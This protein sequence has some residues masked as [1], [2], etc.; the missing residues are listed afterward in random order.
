MAK[1]KDT[2]DIAL[3]DTMAGRHWLHPS[4]RHKGHARLEAIREKHRGLHKAR[5]AMDKATSK[6]E[7]VDK[8]LGKLEGEK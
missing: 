5:Q 8:R 7:G 4:Q 2:I 6:A 1:D 3:V